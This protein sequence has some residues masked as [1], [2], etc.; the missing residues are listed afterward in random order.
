[1][2]LIPFGNFD[3]S[4]V[5]FF[6]DPE[7][8]DQFLADNGLTRAEYPNP[9]GD[10]LFN[11]D[12]LAFAFVKPGQLGY[13]I[14]LHE[15]GH[16]LGL[17]HPHDDGANL[18]PTFT[19]LGIEEF[20]SN[21]WTVMSF[22]TIT[23]FFDA[24]QAATPMP[25]DI[26][27]IQEIY[28]PNLSFHAGNDT[29]LLKQDFIVKTVWD[30][31]GVDTFSA[32][33]LPEGA[34]INLNE[35]SF[36]SHGLLSSTA[37]AF[38]V[39][40][41]NAIGSSFADTLIGNG[42]SNLLDGKAGADAMSGGAGDDIYVVDV[43]GDTVSEAGGGGT[44]T[45]R[46]AVTFALG[47]GLEN[48]LLTGSA[49]IAGTGNGL[50]N[51]LTGNAGANLLTGLDGSDVLDGGAGA[52]QMLGGVGDDSYTVDNAGD[53]VTEEAGEGADTVQ[54]R[55][56]Y[57]LGANLETLL[58]LGAA[59]AGTGNELDNTVTGNAAANVLDGGGGADA[60]AGAL[61][62]D[63]Y[64][65]DAAGDTVSEGAAAGTD[66]VQSA[67]SFV[68]PEHVE[69]LVLTGGAD[70][71]GTGNALNNTITGNAGANRLD[72][73]AGIDVMSGGLGN[74]SYV[75][76]A[77]GD[78]V[79]E[80]LATGGADTVES[81]V[82]FILGANLENLTLTGAGNI[83]GTGNTLNNALTGNSGNNLLDG[84]LGA[85]A[86]SG[87]AGDDTYVVDVIGDTVSEAGGGG[88]DTVRSII[89]WDLGIDLEN[90]TLLGSAAVN[91]TGNAIGNVLTG[92]AAANILSGLGGADQL[93][94]GGG[95]DRLDGGTGADQLSGGAG[96]DLF[97]LGVGEVSGDSI[98]DFLGNGASLGDSLL[99]QGFGEA[100]SLTNSGDQWTVHYDGGAN[101]ETFQIVG[102]TSLS[103]GDYLFA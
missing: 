69:K 73:G 14:A 93:L 22:N 82:S 3:A 20:D 66:T 28:G 37:I 44:D 33:G 27:A 83:N 76:D 80:S 55:V 54:S 101:D 38:N 75:V 43:S 41:E 79:T 87:G 61:G 30:A 42:G 1:M 15:I 95:I 97:V 103:N 72:G 92:N 62:N 90:L 18:R 70:I 57:V 51:Q 68:L 89:S 60:L 52:D 5:G 78:K 53:V 24:G 10:I 84:K 21:S 102:V 19:D 39:T 48:L 85:D 100:A 58:L 29:Y 45:V 71:D 94:G 64:K 88:T 9:E 65:V 23:N 56:S 96:N 98:L 40:I 91:G 36:S 74:D 35:G 47:V 59:V 32:A 86:L 2:A 26:L 34:T 31:G 12:E 7:I 81:G 49:A 13:L 25:F 17:K 11:V 4:A 63:T 67:V 99:F 6:P 46:S 77:V 16:T 50:D 8:A